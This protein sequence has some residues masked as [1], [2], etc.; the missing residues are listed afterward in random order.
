MMKT[1]Q[2]RAELNLSKLPSDELVQLME[3]FGEDEVVQGPIETHGRSY[4]PQEIET[5]VIAG[6]IGQLV[7]S[8]V[9]ATGVSRAAIGRSAGVTRAR[10]QQL[11]H[12]E[13]VELSTL[14][15]I[16]HAC[17]YLLEVT[18]TPQVENRPRLSTTLPGVTP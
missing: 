4:T 15:R 10:I 11:E 6:P 2:L 5:V 8:A 1:E 18:F 9:Q 3:E 13:N 16:A 14:A 12:S 7:A 17:G